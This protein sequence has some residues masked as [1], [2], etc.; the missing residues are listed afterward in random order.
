MDVREDVLGNGPV[1]DGAKAK[2]KIS[3][4]YLYQDLIRK[5]MLFDIR[6]KHSSSPV[7]LSRL[8]EGE[9]DRV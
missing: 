1:L 2:L 8:A 5:H 7:I 4:G 6:R 3:P 9:F